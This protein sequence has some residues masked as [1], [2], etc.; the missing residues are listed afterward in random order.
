[1][2]LNL[3]MWYEQRRL[4]KLAEISAQNTAGNM[5]KSAANSSGRK[6]SDKRKINMGDW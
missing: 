2:D 4:E 3:N 6:A 5:A 1:M